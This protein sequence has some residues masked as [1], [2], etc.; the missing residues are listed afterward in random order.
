MALP[1][2]AEPEEEAW[3]DREAWRGDR[4]PDAAERWQEEVPE[5][6]VRN[7]ED[8]VASGGWTTAQ[9]PEDWPEDLAGPEYWMYKNM[10][11]NRD[12]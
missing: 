6:P 4:Y 7:P 5:G 10:R 1:W 3:S 8:T 2:E 9:E 12:G 11:P